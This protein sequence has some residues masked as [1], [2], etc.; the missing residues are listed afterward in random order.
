MRIRLAALSF[1]LLASAFAVRAA[2]ADPLSIEILP[3]GDSADRV[4]VRIVFAADSALAPGEGPLVLQ[5][6]ILHEGQVVRNFR[7]ILGPEEA[8]R[9]EM[10]QLVSPGAVMVEARLLGGSETAPLLLARASRTSEIAPTGTLYTAGDDAGAEEILAEGI[11]PETTGAVRIREPRRDVAPNLFIVEVDVEDPVK[12]VEFWVD[13]KKLLTRNGPPYR[14]EL[15]LGSVPQ[16]VEVKVVGY[17][18]RGRFVESDAWI[19]NERSNDIEVALT[20][21]DTADGVVHFRVSVQ[22]PKRLALKTVALS[23]DGNRLIEWKR[24]PYA[25]EVAKSRLAGKDFVQATV[26]DS[27]GA[28]TSDLLYLDPSRYVEEVDVNMVELP[29]TVSDATGAPIGS[30]QKADFRVL[31]DGKA[32]TIESFGFAADLP[33]SVGVL[34]DHSGSMKERI[35][36]ARKAALEFFSQILRTGDKA[37]FGGFSF[38]ARGITPF[39]SEVGALQ[40]QVLDLPAAEGGTALYDAIITGLYRFRAVQGRKALVIVTDGD[41]TV[42]K[43]PYEEMLHYVRASRVP[44]YFIGVGL[45]KMDFGVTGKLRGLAAET[46]GVA[47]FIGNASELRATYERLEAELRS[48]YLLGYY[49]ES[50]KTDREYRAIEVSVDR[51][52]AKVRTIRGFVP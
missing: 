45:G 4:A 8:R 23:L 19:V 25:L 41:D 22:N 39:T 21:T 44:I 34:V 10:V 2:A 13:G 26:I 12:R 33:L 11:V 38:D 20:R 9:F 32:Q 43:V 42:S 18:A 47:F 50:S 36:E 3:L 52:G 28:E 46:G 17:D 29:V 40:R 5:G 48:Q 16:R 7:R 1:A 24:P 31:E 37:F 30:L 15:D 51:P 27:T 35:E 49:T 14:T 6:T